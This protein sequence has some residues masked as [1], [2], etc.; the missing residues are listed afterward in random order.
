MSKRTYFRLEQLQELQPK[1]TKTNSTAY[2]HIN[3]YAK[4]K[5]LD[6]HDTKLLFT[7]L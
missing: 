3:I 4:Y 6:K 7:G 5:I 2:L 1:K